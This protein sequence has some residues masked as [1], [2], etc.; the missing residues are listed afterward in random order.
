VREVW[1]TPEKVRQYGVS[2]GIFING[3]QK[4]G[5]AETEEAVRKALREEL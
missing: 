3:K 2:Q 1:V 4:L 5:G